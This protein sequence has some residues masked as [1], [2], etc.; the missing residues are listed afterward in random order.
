MAIELGDNIQ[1]G[2]PKPTDSRYLNNQTP[3]AS[4][5]EVNAGITDTRYTGLTVNILGNEYWY[6]DGILDAC[7]IEKTSG[8]GTITGATNGLSTTGAKIKLGGALTG[9]TSLT[10]A[11]TLNICGGANLSA[12]RYQISGTTILWIPR[13]DFSSGNLA[14]GYNALAVNSTGL[15]NNVLG[16]Y[17][18]QANTTGCENI[19][20]G[21]GA[22]SQ[23]VGSCH[24]IGIG[25]SV[26]SGIGVGGY[27]VAIGN[28]SSSPNTTGSFNTSIGHQ[29]LTANQTGSGNTAMGYQALMQ[30]GTG[31]GN[32]ALGRCAGFTEHGSNKLHIANSA[33]KSLIY[34]EFDNEIVCISGNLITTGFTLTT[35]A[36]SGCVLQSDGS[37]NA[38][39]ATP[40]GG[41]GVAVSGT[42]DNGIITYINSTGNICSEPNLT[43]DGSTLTVTGVNCGTTCV[44]SPII[45]GTS[46][47]CAS[48]I[49]ATTALSVYNGGNL[50]LIAPAAS[51]D[52][53]DVVFYTGNTTTA[54]E[55]ARIYVTTDG[56][57]LYRSACDGLT[58]RCVYH[59]GN[60][61]MGLYAQLNGATFTGDII[62][63]TTARAADTTIKALAGNAYNAG[64]EA[65]GASQGTG[66]VF[67][68]QSPT[69]G[70]GIFYNG[71]GA[72]PF[73]SGETADY[74]SFYRMAVGVK[75]V[76]FDYSQASDLVRFR[77][78]I[79]TLTPATACNNTTVATTAFVKAQGYTTCTGTVTSVGVG[80][81]NGLTG[82]GT[83]TTSGTATLNVASHAGTAGSIGTIN[84]S[85]DAI[86][87]NLGTTSITAYRGDCGNAAYAHSID[88][89]QAHSDYLI[90]NGSDTSSGTITAAGFV[91]PLTGNATTA[92]NLASIPTTFIGN[93]PMTVN[94]SGTIYSHTGINFCGAAGRLTTTILCGTTCL[95]APYVYAST[96]SCTVVA[97]ATTTFRTT[98]AGYS[99]CGGTG[100][101]TAVDW[102]ATSDCRIKKN[103]KP[104]T[105]ALS[106]V[107]AL[108]GVCYELCEDG[109]LDMGLIAQEVLCVEPRLVAHSK[110]I[111]E[112]KKYGIEDEILSLKYDKFAGL[113][114]EAIKELKQQNITLQNQINELNFK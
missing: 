28:Y 111:E 62:V 86:G 8:G 51:V 80:A 106:K 34:G 79:T 109:T 52:M 12:D 18:L 7:L 107:D 77:G 6:K 94:V 32:V 15:K 27:N 5:A 99:F 49:K 47:V 95:Q 36:A 44:K 43:F 63:G 26:L 20:I 105:S 13:S 73:A 74:I 58:A 53:G 61:N 88:S 82:G 19:A 100:C 85:A 110:P 41:G 59:T 9:N 76:V 101:G 112:Y 50:E 78:N 75:C 2:A 31:G 93:Y 22:I 65:Y 54:S 92:T 97:C 24:N 71:D 114:V 48:A 72:P 35:G 60:L 45:F 29:S 66:Y 11:Y 113:L 87:V 96:C 40:S 10:G 103:I 83:I 64:F 17:N 69:Y 98:G 108:C 42:T 81:G 90:N 33:T 38:S 102:V 57:L 23:K 16:T 91:G 14:V 39:W 46:C 25:S 30:V 1:T 104:I 21:F 55:W 84:I 56:C 4:C 67:V 68:G 70:G 89:S 3:W 37:G